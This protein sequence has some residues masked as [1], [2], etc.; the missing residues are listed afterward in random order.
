MRKLTLAAVALTILVGRIQADE[1]KAPT[2][3]E[4]AA[5]AF[6]KASQP[7][8]EHKKLQPL[9]GDWTYTC[10]CWMDPSKPPITRTVTIQL[11]WM[12]GGRFISEKVVG[13]GFDGKPGSFEGYGV[14]GYD[15]ALKKYTMSFI[16]NAGTG[17][18]TGT[19]TVKSDGTFTFESAC[20][21]PLENKTIQGRDVIRIVNKNK[22]I[23]TSY[24]IAGDKEIK[25]M[26]IIAIRKKK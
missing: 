26:E 19:G 17:T 20:S 6:A 5:K 21:C 25:G 12:L 2:S 14:L 8:A 3:P 18:S 23:M 9:V 16:C 11:R 1:V 7:G 15:N 24:K 13:T 22:V 10:K 4:D